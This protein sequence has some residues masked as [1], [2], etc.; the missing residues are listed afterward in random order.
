M[1]IYFIFQN[2]LQNIFLNITFIKKKYLYIRDFAICITTKC[3]LKCL[4]CS[5]QLHQMKNK[6]DRNIDDLKNDLL[7]LFQYVDYIENLAIIGG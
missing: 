3:S 5:Q 1:L 7:C 4:K 6:T 2:F